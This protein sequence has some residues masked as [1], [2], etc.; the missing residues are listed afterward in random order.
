M[1]TA[2]ELAR[3]AGII[4]NSPYLMPHDHVLKGIERFAELVRADEREACAALCDQHEKHW[5][6][7]KLY[8]HR[9]AASQCSAAIRARGQ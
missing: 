3:E 7:G 4:T 8:S 2:I 9:H 6:E 1:K 5:L